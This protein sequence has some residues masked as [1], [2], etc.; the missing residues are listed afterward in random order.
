MKEL[1]NLRKEIDSIDNELMEL[2]NKRFKITQKIGKEKIKN[3]QPIENIERENDILSKTYD[4]EEQNVIEKC[5]KSIFSISKEQQ[6]LNSFLLIKDASYTLSPQVHKLLGNEYYQAIEGINL[7]D[8]LNKD[9][10][11]FRGVNITNPYKKD[12]FQYCLENNIE[13]DEHAKKT[14]I[15]NLVINKGNLKAYNTDYLGFKYLI[16][17]NNIV[18]Q[19]K[20][21]M[22]LGN[23]DTSTTIQKVLE[24]YHPNNVYVIVRTIRNESEILYKDADKIK[25]IDIVINATS[26]GVMPNLELDTLLNLNNYNLEYVID[27]NYNPYRSALAINNNFK[28]VNGLDM[29]IEQ[30]RIAEEI[31]QNKCIDDSNNDFI[32]NEILKNTLNLCLIGMPF[33]GKTTL[34][35][36]LS[37]KTGKTFFD[38]DIILKEENLSLSKLLSLGFNVAD[39]RDY[40]KSVIETLATLSNSII[41]TGGGII[42]D[43]DNINILKQKG[44]II[45]IDTPLEILEM[46]IKNDRPLVKD[47]E[48]LRV[49]YNKRYQKYLNCADIIL[50]GKKDIEQILLELE[51]KLNE[52]LNN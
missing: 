20:N 26:Y 7:E 38:S 48:D 49:L 1:N 14:G 32:K 27:V 44:L 23:G 30:A 45:F 28:Y 4:Y 19:N 40:E 18:L 6:N 46:R 10:L 5:F 29:L 22:I 33:S 34:A 39:Y 35:Q 13:L 37:A 47:K 50:D 16:E 9:D 15:I 51:V 25:N 31:I 43:I 2:L 41:S 17:K 52:Y 8:F 3:N 42:E 11:L 36:N 24:E 12:A 21:I